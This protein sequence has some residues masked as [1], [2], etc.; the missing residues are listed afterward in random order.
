[1]DIKLAVKNTLCCAGVAVILLTIIVVFADMLGFH[2]D[3]RNPKVISVTRCYKDRWLQN[4]YTKFALSSEETKEYVTTNATHTKEFHLKETQVG[5]TLWW[6][7]L[8][9]KDLTYDK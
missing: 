7:I 5:K 8:E 6:T 3:E 2:E 4:P 1:M 9:E